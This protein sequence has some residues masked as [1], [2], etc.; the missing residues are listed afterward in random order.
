MRQNSELSQMIW[1]TRLNQNTLKVNWTR[2]KMTQSNCKGNINFHETA[3]PTIQTQFSV[4]KT[5]S[6]L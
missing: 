2:N 3:L 4:N 5:E 6:K 1:K